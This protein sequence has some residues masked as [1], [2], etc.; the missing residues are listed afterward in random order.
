MTVVRTDD[1]VVPYDRERIDLIKRMIVPK[2]SDDELAVFMQVC[3]RTGLDPFARQ[4]YGIVRET[5]NPDTRRKEP[6]MTIQVSIDGA[7]LTA[8]RS[9][10]YGGQVGPLWCGPDGRWRDVWLDDGYPAAAKVGVIRAGFAEPLWAVA[11]W[12]S[13]AQLK[14]DGKPT[15]MW[16]QMPDVM[17]A[18]C[19]EMLALRKA[20]PAELSGL[21][22]A[23]EMSQ[24]QK[25]APSSNGWVDPDSLPGPEVIVERPPLSPA[26][27][28]LAHANGP[29]ASDE[30]RQAIHA[31]L[32]ALR[33]RAPEVAKGLAAEWKSAG[34]PPIAATERFNASDAELVRSLLDEFEKEVPP[35]PGAPAEFP[36]GE[37]P[38]SE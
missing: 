34:I 37:E 1:G 6:K 38:F 28:R 30:E 32:K 31:R 27:G 7:R 20:F 22:S 14:Q 35:M 29:L 25:A 8:Q 21:Y 24:A 18:K 5:W 16:D 10:G 3:N 17:L 19:A 12:A 4:V 36:P 2:A 23:E 11:R 26:A 15:Q 13:Y 9:G 33:D